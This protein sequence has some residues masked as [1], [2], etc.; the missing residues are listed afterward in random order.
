MAVGRAQD[1]TLRYP[2][3]GMLAHVHYEIMDDKGEY[4]DP[5]SVL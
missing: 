5:G 2:S 4:V 1:V 3:Q